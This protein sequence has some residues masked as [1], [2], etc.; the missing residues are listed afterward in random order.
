[1]TRKA[2]FAEEAPRAVRGF[3]DRNG[4]SGDSPLFPGHRFKKVIGDEVH[5]GKEVPIGPSNSLL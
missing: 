4:S 3:D 2:A 1:M 5:S